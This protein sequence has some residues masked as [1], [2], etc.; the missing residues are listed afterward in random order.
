MTKL[1]KAFAQGLEAMPSC[2]EI[3]PAN[4][5]VALRAGRGVATFGVRYVGNRRV[6]A[7]AH[8]VPM[9]GAETVWLKVDPPNQRYMQPGQTQTFKVSVAIP[10]GAAPGRF[11]LRLDV[12]SVDNP[13]EEYDRGP[14][15][16]FQVESAEAPQPQR[17]FPW[18]WVIVAA[19]L[20]ALITG[21][22][23][24]WIND[25]STNGDRNGPTDTETDAHQSFS[26]KEGA[27]GDFDSGRQVPRVAGTADFLYRE[28]LGH[29]V[30]NIR[31]GG[32][33]AILGE[34][35]ETV[36]EVKSVLRIRP[37]EEISVDNLAPGFWIAVRTSEGNFAAFTLERRVGSSPSPMHIRYRLWEN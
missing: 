26:V 2:Y 33:L 5:T 22:A 25:G 13:D 34:D 24:W 14:L 29:R 8:A 35:P 11:G 16:T 7:R 17:G 12:L 20:L 10:P 21:A 23:V 27:L 18:R 1:I 19:L 6:E 37:V 36:R 4:N 9:E 28:R 15:V 3:S 31:G 30:L 32:A